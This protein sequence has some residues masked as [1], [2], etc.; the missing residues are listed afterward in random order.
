MTYCFFCCFVIKFNLGLGV[1]LVLRF[2]GV[3]CS[4]NKNYEILTNKARCF[5]K[6]FLDNSCNIFT[7]SLP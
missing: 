3:A 5:L 6:I 7:K 4:D 2:P 1:H